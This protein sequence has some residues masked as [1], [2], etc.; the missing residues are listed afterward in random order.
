[1]LTG[2]MQTIAMLLLNV[3]H[4]AF[5]IAARFLKMK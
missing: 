4:Y 1:M 5:V 3:M 2:E